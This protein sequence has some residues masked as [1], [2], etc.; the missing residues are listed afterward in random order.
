MRKLLGVLAAA[1]LLVG[2]SSPASAAVVPF[3][4]V[5]NVAEITLDDGE[6]LALEA[7]IQT[8][9]QMVELDPADLT[10]V[11]TAPSVA[12]VAGGMVQTHSPG[13]TRITGTTAS[14]ASASVEVEVLAAAAEI[15]F[16]TEVVDGL[17]VV[18]GHHVRTLDRHVRVRIAKVHHQLPLAAK[19]RLQLVETAVV[20]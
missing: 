10:W 18:V 15:E 17:P 1:A 5:L 12:S 2:V 9:S 19:A 16:L 8:G 11:S 14:G 13:S 6:T 3:Q 7:Y 20:Q 4:G